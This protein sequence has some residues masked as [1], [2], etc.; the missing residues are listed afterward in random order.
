MGSR[1]VDLYRHMP[2]QLRNEIV[3]LCVLNA[4]SHS[5]LLDDARAI[6]DKISPKSEKITTTMV[7]LLIIYLSTDSYVVLFCSGGLS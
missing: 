1:A 5:G 7:S 2:S 6:F 3:D 4:C